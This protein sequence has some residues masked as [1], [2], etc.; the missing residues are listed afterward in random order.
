MSKCGEIRHWIR[1]EPDA[2]RTRGVPETG[3]R[4]HTTG[5]PRGCFRLPQLD[6]HQTHFGMRHGCTSRSF[7]VTLLTLT[8]WPL[9]SRQPTAANQ[10]RISVLTQ[11]ALGLAAANSSETNGASAS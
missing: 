7:A 6:T 4:R 5:A 8:A 3:L 9:D 11:I 2:H 1:V 10:R